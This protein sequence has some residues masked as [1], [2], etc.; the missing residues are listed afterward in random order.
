MFFPS[1]PSLIQM[2]QRFAT[3]ICSAEIVDGGSRVEFY[4]S[5]AFSRESSLPTSPEE[6]YSTSD[7]K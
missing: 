2:K 3:L 6:E 7:V 1:D 5:I 4:C